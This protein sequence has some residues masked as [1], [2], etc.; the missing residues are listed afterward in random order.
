MPSGASACQ[1]A[2]IL[3]TFCHTTLVQLGFH[4]LLSVNMLPTRL[5]RSA[6]IRPR[7]ASSAAVFVNQ[8]PSASQ[9]SAASARFIFSSSVHRLTSHLRFRTPQCRNNPQLSSAFAVLSAR[10]FSSTPS[11]AA[12]PATAPV[13]SSLPPPPPPPAPLT[14]TPLE[15]ISP[16]ADLVIPPSGTA[17]LLIDNPVTHA[18]LHSYSLSEAWTTASQVAFAPTNDHWLPVQS[19]QCFLDFVHLYTGMP[20][21]LSIVA[22]TLAVRSL[23]LPLAIFQYRNGAR[24]TMMRP[25]MEAI[26]TRFKAKMADLQGVTMQDRQQHRLNMQQLM[27]KYQ[28]NPLFTLVQPIASAPIFLSFFFAVQSMHT[29]HT[30]FAAG[31]FGHVFDL[32]AADPYLVLPVLNAVT[33]LI[34]I[35]FLPDPNAMTDEQ[36]QRMK[37]VFRAIAVLFIFLG[38]SF[39]AGLFVYWIASNVFTIFQQLLLRSPAVKRALEIPDTSGV[40]NPIAW[41]EWMGG[42]PKKGGGSGGAAGGGGSAVTASS[43]KEAVVLR[44]EKVG[45]VSSAPIKH[46]GEV[47]TSK[48]GAKRKAK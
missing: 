48:G 7:H 42:G 36:R 24:M 16:S 14:Q 29:L 10:S 3:C 1:D 37:L 21:W 4:A 46:A 38:R 6:A 25:E 34:P 27:A 45:S 40:D 20:W 47:Y 5:C 13:A 32:S 41:P 9:F 30:S 44:N 8:L 35:E 22:A 11:T 23:L 12:N 15:P 19:A 28:C 31:G 17:E 18:P 26:N 33:M 43:V 2:V 39:P